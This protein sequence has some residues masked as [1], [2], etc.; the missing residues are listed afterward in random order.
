MEGHFRGPPVLESVTIYG[1][2]LE[3]RPGGSQLDKCHAEKYSTLSG[4]HEAPQNVANHPRWPFDPTRRV[5]PSILRCDKHSD[6]VGVIGQWLSS[7][8]VGALA[9][10]LFSVTSAGEHVVAQASACQRIRLG[11]ESFDFDDFIV[12]FEGEDGDVS[13]GGVIRLVMCEVKLWYT[14]IQRS[15][16]LR[17]PKKSENPRFQS[18]KDPKDS[19]NSKISGSQRFRD[20]KDSKTSEDPRFQIQGSKAPRILKIRK[21]LKS[22]GPKDFEISKIP[23]VSKRLRSR[24]SK[25]SPGTQKSEV[26]GFKDLKTFAILRNLKTQGSKALRILKIRKTLKSQGPK[27]FEISKIPKRLKTQGFKALRIPKFPKTLKSQSPT[28]L[29]IPKIPKILKSQDLQYPKKSANSK[30]SIPKNLRIPK[31]QK[32]LSS[33]LST[34]NFPRLH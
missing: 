23:K 33:Y 13:S 8:P 25:E 22:Q 11:V 9:C 6:R 5:W 15:E 19:K 26:S 29:K 34:C 20:L 7:P 27:D 30:F 16:D 2:C 24:S 1:S 18:P 12:E 32:I 28:D 21:T 4:K 3:S 10:S 14:R 31:N 17:D